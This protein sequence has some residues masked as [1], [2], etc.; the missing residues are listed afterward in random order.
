MYATDTRR[1][2]IA[3][4]TPSRS[5][6]TATPSRASLSRIITTP[7]RPV[8]APKTPAKDSPKSSK[9]QITVVIKS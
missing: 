7:L 6:I 5:T 2:S 8:S 1:A 4:V 3:T 9:G